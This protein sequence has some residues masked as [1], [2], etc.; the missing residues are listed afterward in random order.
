MKTEYTC[1]KCNR[2]Y[3]YNADIGYSRDN[4]CGPFCDGILRGEEKSAAR[5]VELEAE[6]N[7]LKEYIIEA[8]E[9]LK[10]RLLCGLYIGND[11]WCSGLHNTKCDHCK[12]IETFLTK[13]NTIK[14]KM[15]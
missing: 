10:A 6:R 11:E 14:K 5:I 8:T 9:L 1:Q 13:T 15:K 2:R 3:K 4:I 12:K 7:K